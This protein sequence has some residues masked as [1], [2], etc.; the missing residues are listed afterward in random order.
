[1]L[2]VSGISRSKTQE[3]DFALTAASSRG[4][5]FNNCDLFP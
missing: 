1:M 3:K 4:I 2:S 5:S